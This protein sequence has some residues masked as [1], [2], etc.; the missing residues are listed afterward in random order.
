MGI[1]AGIVLYIAYTRYFNKPKKAEKP[2]LPPT[3]YQI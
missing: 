3:A 2:W 1:V